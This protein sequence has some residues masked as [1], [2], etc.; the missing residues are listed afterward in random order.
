MGFIAEFETLLKA[1][2]DVLT[3]GVAIIAFSLFIYAVTFKQHDRVTLT[4]TLLLLSIVVI[5]GA[6]AFATVAAS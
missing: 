3:A 2:S 4:F 6:D 1:I 5:F